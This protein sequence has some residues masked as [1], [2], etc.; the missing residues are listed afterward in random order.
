[1]A[2]HRETEEKLFAYW[3]CSLPEMYSKKIEKL[4]EYFGSCS[5]VFHA[6]RCQL[7]QIEN[8]GN[9]D[10]DRLLMDKKTEMIQNDYEE[11][12]K[13][14][15]H[16]VYREEEE[17]PEKLKMIPDAPFGLFYKGKLPNPEK[18]S[19]AVVGA[20]K[21]T[22]AGRRIAER[23]G[24][25]LAANGVQVISGMALGIDIFSQKGAMQW[26]TGHTYAVLGTGVDVC[27]PRSHIEMYMRMQGNG[28]VISEFPPGTPALPFHFPIR[29]RIISGLSDGVLVI[30]ARK[31]SGSLIT[32]ECGL[33][34]GKEIFVVPGGISD[35]QYEGGNALLKSGAVLVTEVKDILDGLGIYLDM[36]LIE[37]KKK[38]NI[39]LETTEKMVY[40]ILSLEPIHI[41]TLSREVRIEPAKL[42]EILLSLQKKGAVEMVGNNYFIVKI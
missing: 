4:L 8:I 19:V 21:A 30:E 1:M 6:K 20:R 25:E 15:I 33:E 10:I 18:P 41:S 22:A 17:F 37:R 34:Q 13:Q 3:L 28:G 16:F 39:M 9:S 32:A 14:G 26:K 11:M 2:E 5:A 40:A 31:R 29:N 7:A 24:Y 38:T 23:F 35:P 27:Y 36:D 42:M 12:K